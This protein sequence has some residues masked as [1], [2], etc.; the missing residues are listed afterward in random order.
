MNLLFIS[1][2]YY[3]WKSNLVFVS[4]AYRCPCQKWKLNKNKSYVKSAKKA[5]I[6]LTEIGSVSRKKEAD[7]NDPVQILPYIFHRMGIYR[8]WRAL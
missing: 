1:L 5:K 7:N 3:V 4:F 8:R 2:F 6:P